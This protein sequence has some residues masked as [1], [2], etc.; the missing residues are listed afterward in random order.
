MAD[1]FLSIEPRDRNRVWPITTV[2]RRQWTAWADSE[3][4]TGKPWAEAWA[5]YVAMQLATAKCIVVIW[6][7]HS[8]E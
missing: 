3:I 4:G 8:I 2:L 5:R 6:S 7:R 1:I